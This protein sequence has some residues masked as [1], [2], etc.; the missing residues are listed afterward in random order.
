MLFAPVPPALGAPAERGLSY[1]E[2]ESALVAT[3]AALLATGALVL[4]LQLDLR[5]RAARRIA[6][7]RARP[8][9]P[10]ASRLPAVWNTL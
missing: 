8:T 3:L 10:S 6:G 2:L 5:R 4:I 9:R 7:R 1:P